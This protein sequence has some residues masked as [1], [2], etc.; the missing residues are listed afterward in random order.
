MTYT[1]YR[2]DWHDLP[3]TDTP[4]TAA[5]MEHM[6]QGIAEAHARMAVDVRDFGAVGDGTADDTAAIQSAVNSLTNGGLVVVPAGVFKLSSTLEVKNKVRLIGAG[7]DA[8][9]L[10]AAAAF[11][12]GSPLV[13]LGPAAGICFDS[14]VESMTVDCN[15][16]SDSTGV[17]SFQGQ[18]NV[19]LS[20]AVVSN[21]KADGVKFGTG[22]ANFNLDN[23][24]VYPSAAGATNGVFLDRCTGSNHLHRLTVGVSGALTVGVNMSYS[25]AVLTSIHVETCTDGILWAASDG[26]LVGASGPTG[27]ADVTNLVRMDGNSRYVS[28]SGLT[29][30]L[31]TNTF[32][33][34][35]FGRTVT[36]AFVPVAT[37][38]DSHTAR[39]IHYGDKAGFYGT[40]P[41]VRPSGVAVTA[42]GV[43]AALVTLGLISA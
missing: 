24:E 33:D 10:R 36:E 19:G 4:I 9:V 26:A 5:A 20:Y 2:A 1:P 22:S 6:E 34:D 16:V 29:R 18:E 15:N 35:F 14:R 37:M 42:A 3:A 40:T 8:T 28:L 38:G 11:A 39:L 41:V 31:C 12:V 30:N 21:F 13:R 43:H 7:R 17:Y 25:S 32:K 23:L 27:V